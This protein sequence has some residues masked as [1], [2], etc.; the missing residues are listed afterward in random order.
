MS[1]PYT[2]PFKGIIYNKEKIGDIASCVCPPYDVISDSRTYFERSPFNA[3]RLELPMS[4]PGVDKYVNAQR[5]FEEW[6]H[7]GVLLTDRA[8]TIYIY[9]QIFEIGGVSHL[10][11]GFIALNKLD[12]ERILTHEQTRSKAK[13]DREKLIVSLK[14][15]TSLVFGLYE[16]RNL[17]IEEI[18]QGSERE[19]LYN[20]EDEQAVANRF[21]R[22]S[23]PKEIERLASLMDARKI[24][25]A[26]GH[27]RLDVSY[28][29]N[30][31]YIPI[32]LANMY[33]EGIVI[34]PYHRM[35]RFE[36]KRTLQQIL[37]LLRPHA[38]VQRAPVGDSQSVDH[39]LRVIATSPAPA[40]GLYSAEDLRNVYLL[41]V[42]RPAD[43][44]PLA[45]L[46]VNM[47]HS[48]LLKE[49][50]GVREE[51]ISF[52]QD[53]NELIQS[54]REGKVDLAFLL[55]PTTTEEVKEVADN[56]LDMPPKSTFFYPK[57]LTG[58]IY[59]RY[60]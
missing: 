15:F 36:G 21:Y 26:D 31:S 8:E 29:L 45:R 5:T 18:L 34:L 19:L 30:I 49:V 6:L 42:A 35:I 40:F 13:E 54:V 10:R 47:L 51:E 9:E 17:E 7:D 11:R 56:R 20:F 33:S 38:E 24:Y 43:G 52:T 22:M 3:I 28:R 46:K 39:L 44:G 55:P 53:A 59:H 14:A 1:L 50:L 23:D 16:D 32:Y 25:V 37:S 48:G 58:L 57:I 2:K 4:L 41:S 60:A 12:K 27:H